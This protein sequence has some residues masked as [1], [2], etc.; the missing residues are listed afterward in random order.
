MGAAVAELI[1]PEPNRCPYCPFVHPVTTLVTD[2]ITKEH[3]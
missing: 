2:H 3:L 1:N